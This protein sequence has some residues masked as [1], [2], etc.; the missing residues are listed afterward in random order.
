MCEL[1]L[2]SSLGNTGENV[3]DSICEFFLPDVAVR[4]VFESVRKEEATLLEKIHLL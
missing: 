4:G 3:T 1:L 2:L